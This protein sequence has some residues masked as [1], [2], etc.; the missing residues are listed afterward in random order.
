M[1]NRILPGLYKQQKQYDQVGNDSA[2][3]GQ[4][5]KKRKQAVVAAVRDRQDQLLFHT[6][7]PPMITF[8]ITKNNP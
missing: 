8:I 4:M 7:Y 3:A 1:T 2:Q 6:L 5:S